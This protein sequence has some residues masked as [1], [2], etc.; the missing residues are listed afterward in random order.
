MF[1]FPCREEFPLSICVPPTTS[2]VLVEKSGTYMQKEETKGTHF[3][4]FQVVLLSLAQLSWQAKMHF[5]TLMRFVHCYF[6]AFA[7]SSIEADR[8]SGLTRPLFRPKLGVPKLSQIST[9]DHNFFLGTF[10]FFF[11][12]CRKIP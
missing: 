6:A 9:D 12:F 2:Y 11:V 1:H 3:V 10:P 4:D 5:D 8:G 7:R